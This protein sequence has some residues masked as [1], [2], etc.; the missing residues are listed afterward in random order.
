MDDTECEDIKKEFDKLKKENPKWDIFL[1][2]D[3]ESNF[4]FITK[5]EEEKK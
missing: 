2:D 1:V 4:D 3:T 5:D